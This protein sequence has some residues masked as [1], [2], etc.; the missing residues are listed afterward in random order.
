MAPLAAQRLPAVGWSAAACGQWRAAAQ[1]LLALSAAACGQWRTAAQRLSAL[2]AASALG[3]SAAACGQWRAAAQR[4]LA[5][6]AAACGQ[7]RTAAQRLPSARCFFILCGA[8]QTRSASISN[9]TLPGQWLRAR[10]LRLGRASRTGSGGPRQTRG[11]ARDEPAEGT[12]AQA[13]DRRGTLESAASGEG[14]G[15]IS[16]PLAMPCAISW[17]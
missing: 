16:L 3:W 17:V 10:E 11:G 12:L 2:S 6:L 5:L 13:A 7:W 1:R 4:L 9:S 8:R 15:A 14:A